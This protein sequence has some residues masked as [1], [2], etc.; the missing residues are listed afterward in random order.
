VAKPAGA[1]LAFWE[2]FPHGADVGIRGVGRTMAEAFAQAAAALTSTVCD[3]ESVQP[4]HASEIACHAPTTELLLVDWINAIVFAMA[5][6]HK[7]FR[8]FDVGITGLDLRALLRGEPIDPARHEPAVEVK[9]ATHTLLRV[10]ELPD[11][12]WIAQCVIDV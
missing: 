11:G 2:H 8:E 6:E 5:T 4:L 12:R 7:V 10:A 3:L 1:R 9:G